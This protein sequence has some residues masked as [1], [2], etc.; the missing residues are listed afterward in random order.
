MGRGNKKGVLK[1]KDFTERT[2]C[3][4]S[5]YAGRWLFL[6]FNIFPFGCECASFKFGN[7]GTDHNFL[8]CSF[9]F[10]F[11]QYKWTAHRFP[12]AWFLWMG[13]QL[14]LISHEVQSFDFPLK[15]IKVVFGQLWSRRRVYMQ[16]FKFIMPCDRFPRPTFNVLPVMISAQFIQRNRSGQG[17]TSQP[18]IIKCL[19]KSH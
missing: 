10:I 1:M 13:L 9:Q 11:S 3:K 7:L 6:C 2:G 4:L 16:L 5:P 12:Y 17:S 18:F 8:N 14:C 15:S 19:L